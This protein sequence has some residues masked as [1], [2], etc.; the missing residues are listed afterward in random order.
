MASIQANIN[1]IYIFTMSLQALKG[2]GNPSL[3]AKRGNLN[4]FVRDCFAPLGLAMTSEGIF[5]APRDDAGI[6]AFVLVRLG[7]YKDLVSFI[8]SKLITSPI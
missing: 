3:R 4:L 7:L 1:A 8:D 6:I 2:R 5:F